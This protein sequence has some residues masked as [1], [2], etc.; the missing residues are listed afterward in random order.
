[1]GIAK[2][3]FFRWDSIIDLNEAN[4]IVADGLE[5]LISTIRTIFCPAEHFFDVIFCE[6]LCTNDK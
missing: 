2:K 3:K 4:V 1:M 5:E 6:T